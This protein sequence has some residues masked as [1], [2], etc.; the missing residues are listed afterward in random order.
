M[1][2]LW[3]ALL[4]SAGPLAPIQTT[5]CDPAWVPTF[6]SEPGL[7]GTAFASVTFDDG[8]GPKL[9]VGGSFTAAGG[10]AVNN[11]A[12]WDGASWSPVGIGLNGSVLALAVYD[13][14]SGDALYAGGSFS[15]FPPL[16]GPSAARIAKWNGSTWN[17]VGA[18]VTNAVRALAV[19]DDGSG[20]ALFAAGDF[21]GAGGAPA[22]R[23]AKWDGVDWAPL[24]GGLNGR[25][26]ALEVH[27]DTN[28]T[29]LYAGGV[30]T[31]ASSA[32]A[33]GIARWNGS[34]WRPVGAGVASSTTSLAVNALESFSGALY[35]AGQFT[36]AGGQPASNLAAWNGATYAAVGAGTNN[37]VFALRTFD[38]GSGPSL[39][40]GGSFSLAG[41]L[42]TGSTAR[43]NGSQ[44]SA[45]N[46]APVGPVQSF[47]SLDDGAG[48]RLYALGAFVT[49]GGDNAP[50]IARWDGVSFGPLG[51]GGVNGTV[52]AVRTFDDG[53]GPAVYVG[54]DFTQIAGQPIAYL[55]RWRDGQ[56]SAVGEPLDGS[57]LALE[58]LDSGSG[59]ALH[60]G[61]SFVQAGSLTV[62]GLAAWDGTV[63]TGFGG[64][65]ENTPGPFVGPGVVRALAVHDDGSGAALYVGGSFQFAGGVSANGVARWD[66]SVWNALPTPLPTGAFA[67]Y[68]L[69]EWD[70][71]QGPELFAGLF[72]ASLGAPT[73]VVRWDGSVWSTLGQGLSGADLF[74]VIVEELTV[75]DDGTGEALYAGGAFSNSGTQTVRNL[76]RWNGS[77]WQEVGGGTL[78]AVRAMAAADDG[79]GTALFVGGEFTAVGP[80]FQ[81]AGGVAR[82]DGALWT[83]MATTW[84]GSV[85]AIGGQQLSEGP[86]LLVGGAFT[87]SPGGD[88]YLGKWKACGLGSFSSLS[89]CFGN[90]VALATLSA[91]LV[92]GQTADFVSTSG[93]GDG[94]ALLF[95]G[96]PIAFGTG[97]GLLVPGV[98]EL[99]LSTLNGPYQVGSAI[100]ANGSAP[101]QVA[102]PP[103]PSLV[104]LDLGF[105]SA[106]LATSVPGVPVS[107]SNALLGRILP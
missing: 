93:Q 56:W 26:N 33:S 51:L 92:Q 32:Q 97:C 96:V 77:A 106:H 42:G 100:T 43:W 27:T 105:Q 86:A 23:I 2:T 72:S 16:V 65:V 69:V 54:G 15:P 71:G 88:S 82:F 24:L 59:P 34:L 44:W 52:Q 11:I 13:D 101:F 55:A 90:S 40:V 38:D 19:W 78:G 4:V 49:A 73:G 91:G 12:A 3:L 94:L 18:G 79:T 17:T 29:S 1:P 50:R 30:F 98:G 66:G 39:Y 53:S 22:N 36:S 6:G 25:V 35:V 83:P 5:T 76:G 103:Q 107:L 61:G 10:T 45:L 46:G 21:T 9:Y 60:V 28:G 63:W 87:A 48:P 41:G 31:Q 64:G 70:A 68:S 81:P 74:G 85:L 95:T 7:N 20:P 58:V 75:F 102:V 14:G 8:S 99:L 67:V 80:T 104:G 89:G 47:G 84:T 37:S 57:V 62:K